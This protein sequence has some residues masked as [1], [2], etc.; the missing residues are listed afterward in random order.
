MKKI[1]CAIYTRKSAEEGRSNRSSTPSMRSEK[2]APRMS[3]AR[4]RRAG[5]CCQPSTRTR[6]SREEPWSARQPA[7]LARRHRCRSRRPDRG[8]QGRPADPFPLRLCKARRTA[9]GGRRGFRLGDSVLQ[10]RDQ[11]GTTD[12]AYA[13]VLR[14]IRTRGHGAERIRDKIAAVKKKNVATAP[15]LRLPA[16]HPA[17]WPKGPLRSRQLPVQLDGTTVVQVIKQKSHVDDSGRSRPR[18]IHTPTIVRSVRTVC[19]AFP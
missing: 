9:R 17:Q 5:C 13:A 7:A 10:N 2:P 3:R 14:T 6:G 15:L 12:T 18:C 19:V 8:L 11:H 1:R 16:P 4:K